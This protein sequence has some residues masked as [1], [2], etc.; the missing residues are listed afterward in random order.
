M[1]ASLLMAGF[2]PSEITEALRHAREL[3]GVL[4]LLS[5][6]SGF[7]TGGEFVIDGGVMAG[8]RHEAVAPAAPI[9]AAASRC[10]A[11]RSCSA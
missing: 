1:A 9:T 10:S 3:V 11:R 7:A 8:E 4:Y 5:D 2:P 6:E